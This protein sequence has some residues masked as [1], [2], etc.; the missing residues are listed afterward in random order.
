MAI[1]N[2]GFGILLGLLV[3]TAPALADADVTYAVG[4]VRQNGCGDYGGG[5][6]PVVQDAALD[7]AA[8]LLSTGASLDAAFEAS[9]YLAKSA[10]SIYLRNAVG[11]AAIASVLA[12]KYCDV[13]A[14]PALE[15][16]G[17]YSDGTETWIVLAR[18][19][20]P[21]S[22]SRPDAVTET[23]LRLINAA[24]AEA[25]QCGQVYFRAALPLRRDARLDAA[26]KRQADDLVAS[27]E[28]SHRG[29]DG[30]LP[31]ERVMANGYR[32]AEVAENVAADQ[33]EPAAVVRSWLASPGHC[34]ALMNPS[35]SDTGLAF[36]SGEE[37]GR[38]LY[39]VQIYASPR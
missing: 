35:Y 26:A 16:V 33:T 11:R 19:L 10:H 30:S 3:A 36:A 24:R 15:D 20:V 28:L 5:A 34:S 1:F 18:R 17:I 23:L 2:R 39:W 14:D 38:G 27:G 32:W 12:R 37:Q 31:G 7:E 25:R 22:A 9:D 29:A 21:V 8:R 13:V 6:P 4:L